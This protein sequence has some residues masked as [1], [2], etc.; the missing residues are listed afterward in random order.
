MKSTR[1]VKFLTLLLA[2]L[3]AAGCSDGDGSDNDNGSTTTST[4][5]GKHI[6]LIIGDG[7]QLEHE[8]AASLY[9][10]GSDRALSFHALPEQGYVSTWDVTTYDRFAWADGKA[11]YA[12]D[13]FNALVG[14]APELG[15]IAPY[16]D[17]RAGDDDYFLTPLAKWDNGSAAVP[18]TDSASAA[19]A[20]ATG[21]KTDDG[22]IAW[23]AGDPADGALT[24]IMEMAR[25][26]KG[27]AI[28][29]V[30][31]VPFTHATP[32]AFVSHNVNRNNYTEIAAE[33]VNT[34]K[35]EVVIGA[36]HP[37]WVGSFRYIAQAE[38]DA[39][40]DGSAGY[41]F[42]ERQAGVNGGQ[43]LLDAA[44]NLAAGERLFGLF[45]GAGGNFESPVPTDDGTS[46]VNAA[47]DENPTLA[48]ATEAALEVLAR[49]EDGFVLMIEQGD[50][51][52]ANH[53]NDYAR[54]VGTMYDLDE[55]VQAAIDFV[56]RDGD[57]ID[58][59]NTLLVVTSDHSNSYMRIE[60]ASALRLG[61]LP[62]QQDTDGNGSYNDADAYPG[63]EVTYA[64]TGHSNELVT[65]YAKGDAATLLSQYEG[66][67]YAG[68]EIVDNTQIYQVMR[69]AAELTP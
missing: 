53:G 3:L 11:A 31:T 7:M 23:A 60:N 59:S 61:N 67:W 19:T 27:A 14:Y 37:D 32:A 65:Y 16:P 63:G 64:T 4:A 49:D 68:S 57:A 29:V 54:M 2:G 18:A 12:A 8:R 28:G 30:S 62:T 21:S 39:L 22:N 58:W 36:G 38:Y 47:T 10:H 9:L 52:W 51:D 56:D 42:V 45:G 26:Q 17:S 15:G 5:V 43:A 13:T 20:L 55:A 69:E 24:T 46:A 34:T 33:I 6:I 35:P 41:A 50:I 1:Y 48:Q 44:G 40:A 66:Q 25:G